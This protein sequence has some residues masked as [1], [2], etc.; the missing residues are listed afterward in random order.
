VPLVM[1]LRVGQ[2]TLARPSL[3]GGFATAIPILAVFFI[4]WAL[5]EAVG[6]LRGR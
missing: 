2:R 4:A 3:R 6:Y 5:G 1:L